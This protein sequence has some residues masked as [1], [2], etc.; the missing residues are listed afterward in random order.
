MLFVHAHPDDETIATG[1][2]IATLV[3]NG[4]AVTV[5]TCTRGERGE[6]VP[7]E[8]W[9]LQG[10]GQA[11]AEARSAELAEAMHEL[12][13]TDHRFLGEADARAAG[14]EPRRYLDSGM[15]WGAT[16]A[17]ALPDPDPDSLV[18]AELAE[19]VADIASVIAAVQPTAVVSY[20]ESG[21]YG[22]PD[23]RVTREAAVHAALLTRVPYF[24]IVQPGGEKSGDLV[25]DV[26]AALSAKTGA[27]RAHRTQLMVD[28]GSIVHSGGQVEPI[29]TTETFRPFWQPPPRLDWGDLDWGDLAR[30]WKA[31]I[32]VLALLL[33]AIVG[34]ITT[35]NHQAGADL[36][37]QRLPTG[38]VVALAACAALLAGARLRFPTRL[39]AGSGAVGLLLVVALLS[40][41][42]PGGSVLVPANPA[43]WAWTLGSVVITA[44]ALAWP[45]PGTFSR[46]TMGRSPMPGKDVDSP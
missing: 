23:H 15:R 40:G 26:S 33:G 44:V 11:L 45:G 13:V 34:L 6:V 22:H 30:G 37:G 2:T 14:A 8:L 9:H 21:G 7:A 43:G 4:S 28:E 16:G 29:G 36:L 38:V 19:I 27:L 20:D 32:A 17:E 5:L 10:D 3:G 31:L 35:V 41:P 1:G 46:A 24:S 42:G 12:G 25:V 18:A 39:V